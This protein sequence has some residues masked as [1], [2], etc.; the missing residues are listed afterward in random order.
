M[1]RL[2]TRKAVDKNEGGLDDLI[3]AIKTGKAFGGDDK[4]EKPKA[5][6]RRKVH[7]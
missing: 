3:E 1:A 6:E 7:N 4:N 2:R 5:R